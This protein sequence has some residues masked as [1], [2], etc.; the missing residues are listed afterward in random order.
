MHSAYRI[1]KILKFYDSME[2]PW[3]GK[4]HHVQNFKKSIF[5]VDTLVVS[6]ILGDQNNFSKCVNSFFLN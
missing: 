1:E 4:Y 5:P 2:N 3:I 6:G